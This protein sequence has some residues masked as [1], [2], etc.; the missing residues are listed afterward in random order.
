MLRLF[1]VLVGLL[2]TVACHDTPLTS[3]LPRGAVPEIEA[4]GG[5][6]GHVVDAST[7][8][9]LTDATVVVTAASNGA[10]A[11]SMTDAD[12]RYSLPRLAPGRYTFVARRLGYAPQ[13]LEVTLPASS[14]PGVALQPSAVRFVCV[15]VVTSPGSR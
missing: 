8:K 12:G 10:Q 4:A 15:L 13:T 2:W 3:P 6:A 7:G 11:G 14:W 9:P 5:G 1:R